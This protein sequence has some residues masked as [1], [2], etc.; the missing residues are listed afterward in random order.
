M[1]TPSHSF[2]CQTF[3][4]LGRR[5][6]WRACLVSISKHHQPPARD[7]FPLPPVADNALAY[8]KL[9]GQFPNA[10][11][12]RDCMFEFVHV[13]IITYVFGLVNTNE[14]SQW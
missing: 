9:S 12:N 1:K 6:G 8:T 13:A 11:G 10:A 3:R 7:A 14:L 5:R 4:R 2:R